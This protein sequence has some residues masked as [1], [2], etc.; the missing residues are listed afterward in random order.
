MG[1]FIG[2]MVIWICVDN[3]EVISVLYLYM[4][5]IFLIVLVLDI[6]DMIYWM[7][8]VSCN[9]ICNVIF[10]CVYICYVMEVC[11]I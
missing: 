7:S 4:N 10:I 6:K 2:F 9:C 8:K 5:F 3:N 11:I 1:Y